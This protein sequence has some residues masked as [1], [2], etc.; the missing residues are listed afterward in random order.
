LHVGNQRARS[1]ALNFERFAER[2]RLLVKSVLLACAG[3]WDDMIAIDH[4]ETVLPQLGCQNLTDIRF[5]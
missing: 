2:A 4:V 5:N 3:K 1:A